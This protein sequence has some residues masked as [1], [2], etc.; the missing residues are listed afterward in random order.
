MIEKD[1][2]SLIEQQD[3]K[4][5]QRIWDKVC[6]HID[7]TSTPMQQITLFTYVNEG[8]G[9]VKRPITLHDLL[10]RLSDKTVNVALQD[11]NKNHSCE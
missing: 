7:L 2:H 11:L 9:Y 6:A 1:I 10:V 8:N 3:P 4:A 5:K